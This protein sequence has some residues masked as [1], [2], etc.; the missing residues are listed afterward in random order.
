MSCLARDAKLILV[1]FDAIKWRA[2]IEYLRAFLGSNF[3]EKR[4]TGAIDYVNCFMFNIL[5]A[6][7]SAV[8]MYSC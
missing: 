8:Q 1:D 7:F 2:F 3:R 5:V 4:L 6:M